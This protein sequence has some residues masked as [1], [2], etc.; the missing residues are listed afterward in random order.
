MHLHTGRLFVSAPGH[1]VDGDAEEAP[2]EA[3]LRAVRPALTVMRQ[4]W[5]RWTEPSPD[6]VHEPTLCQHKGHAADG[7]DAEAPAAAALHAVRPAHVDVRQAAYAVLESL[8]TVPS[9]GTQGTCLRWS[10]C[11]HHWHQGHKSP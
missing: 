8:P 3:T 2:T 1:A 11:A 7:D 10:S 9:T 5:W 6:P 4:A